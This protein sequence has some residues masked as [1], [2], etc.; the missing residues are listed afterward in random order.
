[1]NIFL[2]SYSQ[3]LNIIVLNGN[4]EPFEQVRLNSPNLMF[5]IYHVSIVVGLVFLCLSK[6]NNNCDM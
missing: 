4:F 5:F 1:M 6:L 3:Q 2:T